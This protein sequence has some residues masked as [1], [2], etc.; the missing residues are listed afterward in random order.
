MPR[1]EPPSPPSAQPYWVAQ[2]RELF[3]GLPLLRSVTSTTLPLADEKG[4][5]PSGAL[6]YLTV[7]EPAS[8]ARTSF[9]YL[10]RCGWSASAPRRRLRSAS[11][12]V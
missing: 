3:P 9:R 10:I 1:Q 8:Y 11:Y 5:T 2:K 12:S 6:P 7:F 4:R